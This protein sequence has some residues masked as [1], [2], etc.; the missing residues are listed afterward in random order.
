M[1]LAESNAKASKKVPVVP[2]DSDDSD[3]APLKTSELQVAVYDD[4]H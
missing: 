1:L 3:E 4:V 2:I